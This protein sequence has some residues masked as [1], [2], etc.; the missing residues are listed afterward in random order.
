M[1]TLQYDTEKLD[2]LV[3][4]LHQGL[5]DQG[6]TTED[7]VD[8]ISKL[9]TAVYEDGDDQSLEVNYLR[10]AGSVAA[11]NS[12][13]GDALETVDSVLEQSEDL[14]RVRKGI[15]QSI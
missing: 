15:Q 2:T 4:E 9:D 8:D 12:Y 6:L 1:S 5:L 10:R 13:Q 11:I 7:S 14:E 3:E